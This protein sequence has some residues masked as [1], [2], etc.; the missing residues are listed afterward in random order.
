[1]PQSVLQQRGMSLVDVVS[2]SGCATA[3]VM[4][5][6]PVVSSWRMAKERSV[7]TKTIDYIVLQL[8]QC[9]AWAFYGVLLDAPPIWLCNVVGILVAVFCA[10]CFLYA[11]GYLAPEKE[12]SNVL[13]RNVRVLLGGCLFT[14]FFIVIV[15][16][17]KSSNPNGALQVLGSLA[18]V[19]STCLTLSPLMYVPEI[20]RTRCA[21]NLSMPIGCS[22]VANGSLWAL[23]GLG[24]ADMFVF[25]PNFIAICSACVQLVL[26][27]KYPHRS[28]KTDEL[29]SP[30]SEVVN[31]D[32]GKVA[33]VPTSS[34][35]AVVV[36]PGATPKTPLITA[37]LSGSLT[38]RS[39]NVV[40]FQL[41]SS[42]ASVTGLNGL[43]PSQQ[44]VVP[45][46]IE[47]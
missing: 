45:A 46:S 42:Q 22:T 21:S 44:K 33:E 16:V 36:V 18:S 41:N 11:A 30:A 28:V 9:F 7:G 2:W 4:L 13:Q 8:V 39:V 35:E 14:F 31:G 40:S 34:T 27:W 19:L 38:N 23:Y 25:L 37:A 5:S 26:L 29:S 32:V 6:S 12:R 10:Y 47:T 15:I 17:V 1:M 43:G 24:I 3:T 20:M